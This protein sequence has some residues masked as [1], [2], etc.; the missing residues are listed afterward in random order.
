MEYEYINKFHPALNK[1]IKIHLIENGK[2]K[3][4]DV[5]IFLPA[6]STSH[7]NLLLVQGIN[8]AI[9]IELDILNPDFTK[10]KIFIKQLFFE[11][12]QLSNS[13]SF[14]QIEIIWRWFN[15]NEELTNNINVSDCGSLDNCLLTIKK[16][17]KEDKLFSEKIYYH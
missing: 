10:C 6:L 9:Q 7:I 15:L 1:Q 16:Y 2:Y 12:K 13:F 4:K 3:N 17:L 8:N 11:R 5:I 14:E